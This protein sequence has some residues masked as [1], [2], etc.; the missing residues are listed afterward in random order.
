MLVLLCTPQLLAQNSVSQADRERG[1]VTPAFLWRQAMGGAVMGKPAVQAQSAVV[2]LDGGTLK[3]YSVS[4]RCLWTFLERGRFS[5][6]VTRSREGTSYICRTN[7]ILIAVNRSG[8]ELWRTSIGGTLF[9]PVVIGWD[10]RV[11][12][13]T[14]TKMLCYTA[15]GNLLWA[16]EFG[17]VIGCGPLLDQGG[18]IMLA[19]ENG[20]VVRIDPFGKVVKWK[21]PSMPLL[22]L[23]IRQPAPSLVTTLPEAAI[24]P[25][26][27]AQ[28]ILMLYSNGNVQLLD[29]ANPD[30]VPVKLPR[31]PSPPLA[32]AS[33]GANAAVVLANGQVA[34]ISGIDGSLIWA[35]DSHIRLLGERGTA[36]GNEAMVI[37]DDRGIYVLTVSGVTSF[38]SDGRRQWFTQIENASCLPAFDDSGVLYS[39][40]KDWILYAWKLEDGAYQQQTAPQAG[41]YGPA[42]E[43]SYRAGSPASSAFMGSPG[44][45]N[46]MLVGGELE[47]IER[48]ILEG[49]V[50]ENEPKW[51]GALMEIAGGRWWSSFSNGQPRASVTHRIF[52]LQLL[53]RIGSQELIPPLVRLFRA[54]SETPVK[55][56]MAR[57]IGGIGTDINGIAMQEFLA[58]AS[59]GNQ[60]R[61]EQ[62][63]VS[64]AAATGALCRF[65]G[66]PL[67][68]A[69]LRVLVLLL[70]PGY[71]P[72]V[73]QQ[74]RRELYSLLE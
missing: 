6:F 74:A 32:A 16:R 42:P 61:D 58:A 34:L 47:V 46:E 63:L 33:R 66:P 53:S 69:G 38:S 15:S 37:Y 65:S 27:N 67:A 51:I 56:A 49:N 36:S 39:G 10:G 12:V 30:L 29:T 28:S 45:F 20:E 21:Q 72:S 55:A 57:A 2:V 17:S 50:G 41:L 54:E 71:L 5:P 24:A 9:A 19:L 68:S 13:P 3:A 31:L 25:A 59:R 48:G 26:S 7:G 11:F 52:A 35:A 8:R 40:G 4:G 64:I 60:T 44:R 18:G 62:V 23:S 70:S 1:L 43:G 14:A 73:Q 22:L